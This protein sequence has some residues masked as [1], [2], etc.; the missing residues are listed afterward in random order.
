MRPI[1][2]EIIEE[3]RLLAAQGFGSPRMAKILG[4]TRGCA[5][6][7]MTKH[8]IKAAF[9]MTLKTHCIHGHPFSGENLYIKPGS[10]QRVCVTCRN[11]QK[12][13]YRADQKPKD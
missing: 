13:K 2:P 6:K 9:S 4:I 8:G 7:R 5:Q 3:M 12:R 11:E 10:G 1:A